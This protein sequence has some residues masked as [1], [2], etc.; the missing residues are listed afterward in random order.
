MPVRPRFRPDFSDL[1]KSR[2]IRDFQE[3]SDGENELLACCLLVFGLCEVAHI[4]DKAAHA[5]L[6]NLFPQNAFPSQ[7]RFIVPAKIAVEPRL[8]LHSRRATDKR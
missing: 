5:E 6:A 4:C 7:I 2:Q 8:A 3:P 1:Q